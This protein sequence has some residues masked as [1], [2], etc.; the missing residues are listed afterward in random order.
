MI[1]TTQRKILRKA[2]I[3]SV[4]L[5]LA[6]SC[7][8]DSV[9]KG[10]IR[11]HFQATVGG[12]PLIF[13]RFL[14]PNPGGEGRYKIR[15]FLFYMSNVKLIG[16][17]DSH[18]E[19]DSYHLARFDNANNTFTLELT[20]VPRQKYDRLEFAIGVD[21]TA[22]SSIESVGD[23]DPNSRMAWSWDVGYKF[24]LFEGG[25]DVGEAVLP[26]VYHVGFDESYTPVAFELSPFQEE[27]SVNSIHFTVDIRRLFSGTSRIDMASLSTVK[28]D[29][30]D[31]RAIAGNLPRMISLK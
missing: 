11:L 26:L 27:A 17:S 15:S 4:S 28:F 9:P 2:L 19:S 14:Y 22:N 21:E 6:V 18:I 10:T 25:L 31:A 7:A 3:T 16:E 5:L 13:D 29:R 30:Q 24:V 23:L 1:R 8:P 20:D 12:E